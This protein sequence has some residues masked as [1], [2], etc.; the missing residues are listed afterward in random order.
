MAAIDDLVVII[1]I[2][3][4]L[5]LLYVCFLLMCCVNGVC[6]QV[7]IN[8]H[9][10]YIHGDFN[11]ANKVAKELGFINRGHVSHLKIVNDFIFIKLFPVLGNHVIVKTFKIYV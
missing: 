11:V 9:A 10:V 8:Q 7:H 2:P 3:L 6:A 5:Q 1:L 4:A